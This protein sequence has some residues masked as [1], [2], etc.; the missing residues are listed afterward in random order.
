MELRSGKQEIYKILM[1]K[2]LGKMTVE[3]TKEMAG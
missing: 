1:E 2:L 3:K